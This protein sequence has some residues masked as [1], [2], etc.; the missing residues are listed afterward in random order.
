MF[1]VGFFCVFSLSDTA[2]VALHISPRSVRVL[3]VVVDRSRAWYDAHVLQQL[4]C[5][6]RVSFERTESLSVH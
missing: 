1:F 4:Q 3:V 2:F 5:V 6:C